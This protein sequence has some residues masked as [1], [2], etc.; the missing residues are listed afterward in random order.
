MR[1]E[2]SKTLALPVNWQSGEHAEA[3]NKMIAN[4]M[5]SLRKGGGPNH[6][7][8]ADNSRTAIRPFGGT[9]PKKAPKQHASDAISQRFWTLLR[10]KQK[11][12]VPAALEVLIDVE[13]DKKVRNI[14]LTTLCLYLRG[15]KCAGYV[16]SRSSNP[17]TWLLLYNSGPLAPSFNKTQQCIF[18]HQLNGW[19][20][21]IK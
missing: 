1:I 21:W 12:T 6:Y 11:I 8:L 7:Q 3:I 5:I 20:A 18:D 14:A 10:N 4:K 2:P 13:L 17:T 16:S 15:L 9:W 19:V